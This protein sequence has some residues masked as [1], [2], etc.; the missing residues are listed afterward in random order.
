MDIFHWLTL[1]QWLALLRM[2]IGLWWIKSVL[3]KEYPKFV[4]TGM[5]VAEIVIFFTGAWAVWSL[6]RVLGLFV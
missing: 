2:G 6:D 3:H 4:K 5:I 1:E